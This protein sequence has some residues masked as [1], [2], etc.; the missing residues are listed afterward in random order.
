MDPIGN[1]T[2]PLVI[3][4]HPL[5]ARQQEPGDDEHHHDDIQGH[6]RPHRIAVGPDAGTAQVQGAEHQGWDHDQE[7][8]PEVGQEHGEIRRCLKGPVGEE[9]RRA[10]ADQVQGVDREKPEQDQ[11]HAEHPAQGRG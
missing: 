9:P 1:G 4:L 8:E 2:D 7:S 3:D 5:E 11:H 10:D 6:P